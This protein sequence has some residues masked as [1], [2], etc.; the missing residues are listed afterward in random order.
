MRYTIF[1]Y[2]GGSLITV[3]D[4]D[5]M[6]VPFTYGGLV[7]DISRNVLFDGK[8]LFLSNNSNYSVFLREFS[9]EEVKVLSK[10]LGAL[11]LKHFPGLDS[12]SPSTRFIKQ[13]LG[14]E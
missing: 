3:S 5:R 2:K 10:A 1:T 6:L 11:R 13:I 8:N 12:D 7:L 4:L 9:A 14:V